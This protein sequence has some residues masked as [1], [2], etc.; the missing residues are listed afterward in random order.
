VS[1]GNSREGYIS[2]HVAK[3]K[4]GRSL[5][6]SAEP[7]SDLGGGFLFGG[8]FLEANKSASIRSFP[9][10]RKGLAGNRESAYYGGEAKKVGSIYITTQGRGINR[11]THKGDYYQ[12]RLTL[13]RNR[14]ITN[15]PKRKKSILKTFAAG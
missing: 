6:K 2:Q 1:Q 7:S 15:L 9:R 8:M 13:K 11:G 12:I 4:G 10:G 5:H 14:T 3:G